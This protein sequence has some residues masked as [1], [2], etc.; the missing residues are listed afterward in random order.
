MEIDK[1]ILLKLHRLIERVNQAYDGFEFHIVYHSLYDFCV[2]ALSAY[3]LDMSKDRL[4]C[5]GHDSHERRSAQ[6]AMHEILIT[7]IKL[8]A[9]V[10]SFTAEDIYRY[11]P[12]LAKKEISVFLLDMPKAE[13]KYLDTGLEERWAKL[14]ELKELVNKELEPLR[15]R[16]EIS[17]SLEAAVEIGTKGR[18]FVKGLEGVLPMF[19]IVSEVKLVEGDKINVMPSTA[20]KCARCWRLLE[21]V[22]SNEQHPELCGRCA[23]V[24]ESVK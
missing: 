4:Y 19:L 5:G 20:N 13:K 11:V 12:S 7:L 16:K 15:A 8:M 22:G 23:S 2:N 21:D 3:Y 10:L 6:T 1:W 18:D 9:P 24:V 14:F 17:A